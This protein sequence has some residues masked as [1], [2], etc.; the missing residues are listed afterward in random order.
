M[1]KRTFRTLTAGMMTAAMAASLLAGC[2]KEDTAKQTDTETVNEAVNETAEQGADQKETTTDQAILVVSFGTSYNDNRD[3]SIGATEEA[4]QEAFPDYE[5]RRAFT[6]QII[7]DKLEERDGLEIDNV[8]EAL[9]R[10][11]E[12]G[13]KNLVVQPTH[14]MD[15]YEY[16]DLVGELA[17]YAEAFEKIEVG[18]PLLTSDEDFENVVKAITADTKEYDDG[19]TAICFMGHGTEAESNKVYA[20]M[21]ELLTE[22][23]Y[24]NYFVGT[25]E[26]SPTLEDVMAQVDAGDYKNVVLEP[27]MVVAG[28]HANN[29]MAGDEEGSWKKAFEDAGYNV[30]CLIQGLGQLEEI[31]DIYVEHTQDAIN[32]M[33]DPITADMLKD[34]E[35]T[36]DVES[37]ASM[38][39]VV[40]C[41]LTV[42]EGKM[43]AVITMSGTGYTKMYMGSAEE[44]ASASEEDCIAYVETAEGA[45]TFELPVEA[46]NQEITC[47]SY[48]KK[49]A[50]WYDRTLVFQSAALPVDAYQ[51]IEMTTVE[52]MG[53]E[54]GEYQIEVS[55]EGG[56]GKVKVESPV[57]LTVKDGKATAAIRWTS[58]YYDYMLVNDQKYTP[59][60]TTDEISAYEIPVEG[61]DWKMPVTADTIAMSTPHEIDY[62]LYFDSATL[63]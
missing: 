7:I 11:V 47:S 8:T 29:D 34:G 30:E 57:T 19:E 55:V 63:K 13:I 27:L 21:Q 4:I 54:D 46:L 6:S 38:F 28:D 24:D 60:E 48:S 26:A 33:A 1:K 59:T 61:F 31:R 44:A 43:T 25:V 15:G 40:D 50:I 45:H 10:A 37:N 49:K 16:Q 53:L 17:E 41:K 20:K 32:K 39:K 22:E 56:T 12:D 18:A 36:I 23:G 58:P 52:S 14:L 9:D 35:Y 3:L 62:T 2:A 51:E 42:K 5:V